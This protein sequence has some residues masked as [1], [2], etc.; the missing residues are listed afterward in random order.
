MDLII[1]T[2]FID[3]GILRLVFTSLW[4]VDPSLGNMAPEWIPNWLSDSG[5]KYTT[6]E[7]T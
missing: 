7:I 3:N 2:Q 5:T 4:W 1:T 6:F